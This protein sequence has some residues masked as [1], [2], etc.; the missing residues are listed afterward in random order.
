MSIYAESRGEFRTR[1]SILAL[2]LVSIGGVILAS[3]VAHLVLALIDTVMAWSAGWGSVLIVFVPLG[4]NPFS[5]F[6]FSPPLS[7]VYQ[8]SQLAVAGGAIAF[9]IIFAGLWPTSS[10]LS[11]R[12]FAHLAGLVTVADG[13]LATAL[14]PN[15]FADGANA[16]GVPRVVLI[17]LDVVLALIVIAW[18]ERRTLR[19]LANVFE[20]DNAFK[21]IGLWLLRI[22]VGLGILTLIAWLNGWIAGAVALAA[23]IVLTF[24]ATASSKPA[25]DYERLESPRM[26][27][28]AFAY[29]IA[30]IATSAVFIALFGM[31][32]ANIPNEIVSIRE[33]GVTRSSVPDELRHQLR[34][35]ESLEKLRNIIRFRGKTYELQKKGN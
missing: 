9:G 31:R 10:G 18:I 13:A 14:R 16:T 25:L 28:A 7:A 24:I 20:L 29:P 32:G 15:A 11:A 35:P 12:I 2:F 5:P 1:P 4:D 19:L 8:F 30:A 21:R 22:P 27:V 3:Q 34:D 26:I 33:S 17:A 6:F 23:A